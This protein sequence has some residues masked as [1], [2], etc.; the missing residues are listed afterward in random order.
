MKISVITVCFN[1]VETIEQTIK[2]VIEQ[3]YKNIEYI[4]I[5]GN[6]SDGTKEIIQKYRNK[7]SK[8]ISEKDNG[9]Y[10]A[11]NK[12]LKIAK[13]DVVSLLHGNDIF[14]SPNSL[15]KIVKEV[16]S[17]ENFDVI[18][19]DLAFKKNF[20]ENKIY[21]YYKAKN[22][23]TWMLRI[24]YSPPHLSSFFKLKKIKEI[25]FYNSNYRIA[26]DFDFFVK[27]FLVN[28]LKFKIFNECLI[29]MSVGGLSGQ[30]IKSYYISSKEINQS[31]KSN[32]YFSNI[33]ITFIRFPLKL[34]QL[35]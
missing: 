34:I 20:K 25:G 1:S 15:L 11:I 4:I 30:N 23:K 35:L 29:Y 28:N 18:I 19:S 17:N 24:G 7:I 16:N 31:L 6:S 13:G 26:G 32:G 12:G 8:F 14:S 27:S 5:D 2:S 33:L 9:I 21:R 3:S 10:D 22:F